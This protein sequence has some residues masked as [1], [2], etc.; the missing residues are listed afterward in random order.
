MARWHGFGA[1]TSTRTEAVVMAFSMTAMMAPSAV[2][3]FIAYGRDSRRPL[4][5]A[6]VV[7]IYVAVW[8]LIGFTLDYLMGMVM[9]SPSPLFVVAAVMTAVVYAATPWGRWARDRCRE[10]ARRQPRGHRFRDAMNDAASYTGC[11]IVCSAGIMPALVVA[12]MTNALVIVT[13]A[14]VMLT[15]KIAPWPMPAHSH[16]R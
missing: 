8:A 5:A 13:G 6:S 7:L 3:F 11:C 9:M 4:A 15:Y 2:P 1:A 10:M 14:A 12:G 16:S